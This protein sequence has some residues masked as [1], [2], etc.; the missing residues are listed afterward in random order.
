M[1]ADLVLPV[2]AGLGW[3][4]IAGSAV[5]SFRL[6]WSQML[7]MGLIWLAIFLGLYVL[8]A[9]FQVAQGTA[10]ALL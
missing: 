7:K 3:L 4:V 6:G 10:A 5:A 1:N 9:W 2:I 8:V